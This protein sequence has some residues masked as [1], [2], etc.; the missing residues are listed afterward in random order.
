MTPVKP[1]LHGP[2]QPERR[3]SRNCQPTSCAQAPSRPEGRARRRAGEAERSALDG[4][5]HSSM[6]DGVMAAR[7]GAPSDAR[8]LERATDS[9]DRQFRRFTY[10]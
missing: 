6:I 1:S 9:F 3:P 4:A 8:A 7:T 5:E 2:G 10:S